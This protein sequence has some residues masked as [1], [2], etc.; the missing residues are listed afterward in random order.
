[1]AAQGDYDFNDAVFN[2]NIEE[3]KQDGLVKQIAFSVLPVARGAIYDNA[4]KLLINTP[5]SN[6][7][8]AVI[9]NK[10][11]TTVLV[12]IADNQT[13]F[14]IIDKIEDALPPPKVNLFLKMFQIF[15]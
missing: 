9:K 1:M 8:S 14:I 2:Y 7:T 12:P 11:E 5:I 15:K 6:I 10:V 4:L 3:T 13:L